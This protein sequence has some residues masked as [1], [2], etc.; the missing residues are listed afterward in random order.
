MGEQSEQDTRQT[1]ADRLKERIY[2]T[3]AALAVTV[4]LTAHGHVTATEAAGS[5]LVTVLGTLFAVFTADLISHLLVH[6]RFMT[7]HELRHAAAT[8]FSAFGAIVLPLIFLAVAMTGAWSTDAALLASAVALLLA[9]VAGGYLAVRR[10]RLPWWQ[11]LLTLGCEAV[12]G[13]VVIVLQ[14]L[15]H[16]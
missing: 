14:L 11:R 4:T 5:L 10:I 2:V 15:A 9:L 13:A 1:R 7:A 16:T 3:F 6:Q 8:T 12:L